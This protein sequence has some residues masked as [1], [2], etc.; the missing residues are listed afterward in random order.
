MRLRFL[1]TGD[2]FGSG[3]RF[4]TCFW[5]ELESGNCLIDC[6][7]SSL[8]AMRRFNV[9]PMGVDTILISHLHGDHYGGLPFL[10]LLC[11]FGGRSRPLLIAGPPG[12]AQRLW[13]ACEVLFAGSSG[14]AWN[15][16]VEFIEL[17]PA[18]PSAVGPLRVTAHEVQ[19]P[20]GAPSYGLRLEV[21]GRTIAYSGDT[22]WCEALPLLARDADLFI[23]ECYAFDR[24]V[25]LHLDYR[26]LMAER[27]RLECKRM[28]L[29]HMSD[30]MLDRLAEV[31]VEAAH[32][33]MVI[34]L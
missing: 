23:I 11:H 2:A 17:P 19:H 20:S 28:V 16:P 18:E 22:E 21:A 10:L 8:T 24:H 33:G 1:G 27:S 9:D 29:T 15:F 13:Q 14:L 7:A 34:D 31:E 5:L 30:A 32:D 26:T 25:P 4:H 3:G 12:L 6:G